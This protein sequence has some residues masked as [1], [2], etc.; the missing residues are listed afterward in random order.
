MCGVVDSSEISARII[1][2]EAD[3]AEF[4]LG[5]CSFEEIDAVDFCFGANVDWLPQKNAE[6]GPVVVSWEAESV[7]VSFKA[8]A[9]IDAHENAFCNACIIKRAV[10]L[11]ELALIAAYS[12]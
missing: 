9:L 10:K 5:I 4:A 3:F 6:F 7:N 11:L 12:F 2:E 8:A 1:R